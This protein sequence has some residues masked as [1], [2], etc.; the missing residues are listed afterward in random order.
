MKNEIS[1]RSGFVESVSNE[2]VRVRITQLSACADC[3]AHSACSVSDT[4]EKIIEIHHTGE[5]PAIGQPV[6]IVGEKSLGLSA[7]LWAYMLPVVLIIASL[8]LCSWFGLNEIPAAMVSLLTLSIYYLL[9]FLNKGK[10]E[11]RFSFK[12]K[13]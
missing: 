10:F 7:A 2:V 4:S 1:C 11:K 3:H 8:V 5:K 9:L 13:L 6:Q 12:L